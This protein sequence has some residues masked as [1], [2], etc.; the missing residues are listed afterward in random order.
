MRTA[1]AK[2]K[3]MC[4]S[5]LIMLFKRNET[6]KE[7]WA[8]RVFG[9]TLGAVVIFITEVFQIVL[10]AGAIILPVRYFL[11]QPFI[12]KGASMEPSYYDGEYL[13]IDELS[14][15]L[16][17]IE[18]GETIVFHPPENPGQYY[19]KRVIGLPGE[20]I[21]ILNGQITIYNKEYPN[22]IDI[23]EEYI[24][25]YTTGK[26][27]VTL[28]ADEYYLLGD[29]RDA[30]LDSRRIGPI[31]FSNIVGRVWIRGLPLDR[32]GTIQYPDYKI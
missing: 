22:G 15:K 28:G 6:E 7:S 8:E 32:I 24:E 16:R 25:E 11:I 14:Y 3:K 20:T 29:N 2:V 23:K 12:V 21:E 31:P 10:I 4:Y 27:H 18:R 17:D 13:I 5:R 30:S 26:E 9:A 19:I 1:L